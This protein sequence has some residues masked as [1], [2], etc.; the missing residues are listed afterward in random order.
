M[1]APCIDKSDGAKERKNIRHGR[2]GRTASKKV[3]GWPPT[4][5]LKGL[6]LKPPKRPL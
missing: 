5:S 1:E 6:L 4:L 3:G 2:A